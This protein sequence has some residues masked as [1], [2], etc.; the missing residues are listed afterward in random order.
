MRSA[1]APDASAA[2]ICGMDAVLITPDGT[3]R[4]GDEAGIRELLA[5]GTPFW[6]DLHGS[7]Q[8]TLP[9]LRDVFAFHPL[10]VEDAEQ[11]GQRPKIEDYGDYA[12]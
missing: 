10:A 1:N 4:A 7:G 3:R 9:I 5:A 6:L 2:T 8:E 11:F 12:R